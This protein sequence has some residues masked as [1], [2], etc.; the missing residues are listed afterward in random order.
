MFRFITLLNVS[1]VL[2]LHGNLFMPKFRNSI[3]I[4]R[5]Y[6]VVRQA[7]TF[8]ELIVVIANIAFPLVRGNRRRKKRILDFLPPDNT[9]LIKVNAC[10]A[11]RRSYHI[12]SSEHSLVK[13]INGLRTLIGQEQLKW[14][15]L[16]I[17][18]QFMCI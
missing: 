14:K 9:F 15:N 8:I 16:K 2:F 3:L 4:E 11:S 17:N 7:F 6:Y 1:F 5:L 18:M 10:Q 13:V 12:L